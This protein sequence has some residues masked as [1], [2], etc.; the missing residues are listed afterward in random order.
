[1]VFWVCAL[2]FYCGSKLVSTGSVS[3]FDFA[4]AVVSA[5]TVVCYVACD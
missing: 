1:M 2:L 5:P 4:V 3:F